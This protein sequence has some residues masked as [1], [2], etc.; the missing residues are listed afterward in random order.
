MGV[1]SV[2]DHLPPFGAMIVFGV[3]FE[4]IAST[5]TDNPGTGSS[6]S[7]TVTAGRGASK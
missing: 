4:A 5:L 2:S 7:V 6:P 3:S 1:A